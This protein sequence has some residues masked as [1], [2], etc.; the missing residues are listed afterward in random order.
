MVCMKKIEAKN[1]A[2]RIVANF[3]LKYNMSQKDMLILENF[4]YELTKNL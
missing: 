3:G 4:F 1:E 2:A